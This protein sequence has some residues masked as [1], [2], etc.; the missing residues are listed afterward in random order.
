M[1]NFSSYLPIN[2]ELQTP[3]SL[4][5]PLVALEE[6][7]K[8]S[9]YRVT[10]NRCHCR[11]AT[12]CTNYP[13][14]KACLLMGRSTMTIEPWIATPLSVDE[15]I[16]HARYMVELGLTPM[17]GR[18]LMDNLFYGIPNTGHLLTVCFCCHCCCTV[19]NSAKFFPQ[20]VMDSIVRLKGVTVSV[21]PEKCTD[22]T[23]RDCVEACIVKAF[24]FQNGKALHDSEKCKGCGWC[25]TSCPQKALTVEIE[26]ATA[27]VDEFL[28]RIGGLVHYG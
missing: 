16:S 18:V 5:L 3:E 27:A 4:H 28:E 12:G 24:T 17:V 20:E 13:I 7:I 10:I 26:D 25:V 19:M 14:E 22:C 1:R 8:R 6:I 2:E 21:D 11:D 15:A 23:T 9:A